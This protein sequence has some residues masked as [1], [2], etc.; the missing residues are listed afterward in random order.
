MGAVEADA[1][2]GAEA[3]AA[4]G[5]GCF[6]IGSFCNGAGCRSADYNGCISSEA[7]SKRGKRVS[8]GLLQHGKGVME[9]LNNVL[10]VQG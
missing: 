8:A 7:M 4:G 5:D 3:G 1:R 6:D 10:K 9:R 2:G